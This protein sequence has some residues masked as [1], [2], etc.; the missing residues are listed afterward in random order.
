MNKL[1]IIK[2]SKLLDNFNVITS[3]KYLATL[4]ALFK[5]PQHKQTLYVIPYSCLKNVVDFSSLEKA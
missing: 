4:K 2:I 3:A 1:A 5:Y